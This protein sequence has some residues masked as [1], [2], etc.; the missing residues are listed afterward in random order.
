MSQENRAR[1]IRATALYA[2]IAAILATISIATSYTIGDFGSFLP[3]MSEALVNV[4]ISVLLLPIVGGL[5][6]FYLAIL[7]DLVFEGQINRVIISGLYAGGFVSIIALFM[8]L[9]P[10]SE[11]TSLAGL[12]VV[13]AYVVLFTYNILS[14]IAETRGQHYIRVISRAATMFILGQILIQIINAYMTAPGVPVSDQVVLIREMLNWGFAASALITLIG[15]F[16]DSRNAYLSQVGD[17]TSNYL[18]VLG[19]SLIGTLYINFIRGSLAKV[20]PVVQQLSP[21]VEWTGVVVVS[22]MI[23]TV[24]RRGMRETMMVPT[25]LGP[26]VKHVQ[27]LSTTKGKEL[28]DFT[29]IINEFVQKGFKKRLMV[30][31]F[32]FLEE[33]RASDEEI[34]HSLGEFIEHEDQKPPSFGR[35]GVS[36]RVMRQNQERRMRILENTVQRINSLGLGVLYKE[37]QTKSVQ[38]QLKINR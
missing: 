25:E 37:Q 35:R 2:F 36:D 29:D 12:L 18:A 6:F 24:M 31:L 4:S 14:A 10:L 30:K 38:S 16:R 22:A 26:W 34:T 27:D 8:I 20:S 23:F 3:Y 13:G 28:E 32:R 1:L 19:M 11:S 7:L 17:L 5:T 21:Y 33:N 9:Q 15:I